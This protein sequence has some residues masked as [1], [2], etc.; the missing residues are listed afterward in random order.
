MI[1]RQFE[2]GGKGDFDLR[3][4]RPDLTPGPSPPGEGRLS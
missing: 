1:K 4:A 2:K 3:H